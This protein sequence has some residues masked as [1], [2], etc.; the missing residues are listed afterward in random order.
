NWMAN[1][2]SF[3]CPS[4]D[5]NGWEETPYSSTASYESEEGPINV[6]IF[7]GCIDYPYSFLVRFTLEQQEGSWIVTKII[8]VC[9]DNDWDVDC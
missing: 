4:P 8:A 6:S 7:D 2:T 1:R 9:E 3:T 5:G